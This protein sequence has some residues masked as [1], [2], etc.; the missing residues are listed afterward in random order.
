M[1]FA[2]N[3]TVLGNLINYVPTSSS[4]RLSAAPLCCSKLYSFVRDPVHCWIRILAF[5]LLAMESVQVDSP[6]PEP[7]TPRLLLKLISAGFA[8]Y[9][10]GVNDGSLGALIPYI[11]EAYDIDTNM[12]SIVLVHP[13]YLQV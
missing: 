6:E 12:V 4:V 3:F 13:P 8:F 2:A 1:L 5:A 11:R 7:Q 9:V 10:A